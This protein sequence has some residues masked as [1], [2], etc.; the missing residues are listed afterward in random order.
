MSSIRCWSAL[1]RVLY[2]GNGQVALGSVE[3][4]INGPALSRLYGSPIDV[5]HING[6]IFVMS[7]SLDVERDEHRHRRSHATSS[8]SRA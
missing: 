1:D 8:V 6:R 5:V 4:V 3:E 2:L 7:G